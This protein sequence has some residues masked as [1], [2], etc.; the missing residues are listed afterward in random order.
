MNFSFYWLMFNEENVNGFF[1]YMVIYFVIL[2]VY[3]NL[4]EF[5]VEFFVYRV[6]WIVVIVD[7][8]FEF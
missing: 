5:F 2:Y 1:V 3:V 6:C 4:L 8:C 7:E